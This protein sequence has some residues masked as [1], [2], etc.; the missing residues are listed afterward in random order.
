MT[1]RSEDAAKEY[2]VIRISVISTEHS[3]QSLHV[4][5]LPREDELVDILECQPS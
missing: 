5:T 1:T 2:D 3:P 4:C